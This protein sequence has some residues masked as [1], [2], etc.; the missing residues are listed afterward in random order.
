MA[1][2]PVFFPAPA[3]GGV[4]RSLFK[5]R[6]VVLSY[7][8]PSF[9]P[10]PLKVSTFP[11]FPPFLHSL[12]C[13]RLIASGRFLSLLIL[14]HGFGPPPVEPFPFQLAFNFPYTGWRQLRFFHPPLPRV[15]L[16]V[17]LFHFFP[18]PVWDFFSIS[19]QFYFWCDTIERPS[20]PSLFPVTLS[21][22]T[23]R[24]FLWS[25]S[26]TGFPRPSFPRRPFR[27]ADTRGSQVE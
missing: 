8:D 4:P 11:L 15:V 19:P 3:S 17:F 18:V 12:A 20:A 5:L 21:R 14:L 27:A 1:P 2:G 13:V 9:P 22:S 10:P 6:C 24:L 25:D 16:P 26:L 7:V 23:K